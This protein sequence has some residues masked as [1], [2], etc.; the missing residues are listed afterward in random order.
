MTSNKNNHD[1][2]LTTR[3]EGNTTASPLYTTMSRLRAYCF[4]LNNYTSDQVFAFKGNVGSI[5]KYAI[6][7]KET[8]ENNTPHLQGY[9]Q[10]LKQTSFNPIKKWWKD[11]I[12]AQPHIEAAKGTPSENKTYCSKQGDFWEYGSVAEGR[13]DLKEFLTDAKTMSKLQLADKHPSNFARYYKAA[14]EIK[15][16]HDEEK[17]KENLEAE[18][19]ESNLREWQRDILHDL[20]HQSDRE[21]IWIVD[22]KGGKGKTWFSLYLVAKHNAFYVKGGKYA[23]VA[24]AYNKEPIVIFDI[25]RKHEEHAPYELMEKFKDGI[26]FSAKYESRMKIF[27]SAKVLV[28]SNFHPDE[29]ALSADRWN[30]IELT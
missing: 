25:P 16:A 3:G 8:G 1:I 6:F 10:L 28:C 22:E 13:T 20:L 9:V 26:L 12:K 18:Y 27:K 14:A 5:A 21:I 7:G 11:I 29:T 2:L 17:Q 24:Y 30:I 23:D 4:T 19:K 15:K